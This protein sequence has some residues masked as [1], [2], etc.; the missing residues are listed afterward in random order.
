MRN[1]TTASLC[2]VDRLTVLKGAFWFKC[3]GWIFANLGL[4]TLHYNRIYILK[5]CLQ[6]QGQL[7]VQILVECPH[8][9]DVCQTGSW[10]CVMLTFSQWQ[11]AKPTC[12]WLLMSCLSSFMSIVDVSSASHRKAGAGKGTTASQIF[13]LFQW[14]QMFSL[15]SHM[16][17]HSLTHSLTNYGNPVSWDCAH[18]S[19]VCRLL[20][21]G[22]RQGEI[23]T[24]ECI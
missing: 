7:N 17:T 6:M 15:C 21:G 2:C 16:H 13:V 18:S 20:S 11:W 14:K 1:K 3:Q 23:F 10:R 22:N 8:Q 12:K 9:K 5:S 24:L 4:W 19:A